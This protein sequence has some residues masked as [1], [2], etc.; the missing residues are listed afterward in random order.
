VIDSHFEKAGLVKT[1][2]CKI[3]KTQEICMCFKEE[4]EETV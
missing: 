4:E 1:L 2:F 3:E